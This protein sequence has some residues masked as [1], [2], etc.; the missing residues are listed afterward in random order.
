VLVQ[1]DKANAR[2]SMMAT[3]ARTRFMGRILDLYLALHNRRSPTQQT[4][5]Q[6]RSAPGNSG[7]GDIQMVAVSSPSF[8]VRSAFSR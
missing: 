4:R 1:D 7:P 8:F 5:I 3:F 2:T 6:S